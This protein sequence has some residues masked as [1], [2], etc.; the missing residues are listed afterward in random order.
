M[1]DELHD[2]P[3]KAVQEHGEFGGRIHCDATNAAHFGER[4]DV[5]NRIWIVP[6]W[7]KVREITNVGRVLLSAIRVHMKDVTGRAY[8]RQHGSIAKN[9][10]SRLRVKQDPV[11]VKGRRCGVGEA[12]P[13]LHQRRS[14][15]WGRCG[16]SSFVRA[17]TLVVT[18]LVT[19]AAGDSFVYNV[20]RSWDESLLRKRHSTDFR[21]IAGLGTGL[22]LVS[23]WVW[24]RV[25]GASGGFVV[26]KHVGCSDKIGR[27][28]VVP[29]QIGV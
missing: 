7:T 18:L 28:I 22:V 14:G 3:I 16:N 10:D 11:R 29:E 9:A 21:V 25:R 23:I 4:K 19:V 6:D 24:V 17:V 26:F 27:I 2:R 20:V 8:V 13:N 15:C 5:C 1:L 12:V